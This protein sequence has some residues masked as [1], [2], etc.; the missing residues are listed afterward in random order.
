MTAQEF[1]ESH[2]EDVWNARVGPLKSIT[3]KCEK[4]QV[5]RCNANAIVHF[6]ILAG[7]EEETYCERRESI[8]R[9]EE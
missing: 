9:V 5:L 2:G 3:C 7:Q 8:P 6:H 1:I 4:C